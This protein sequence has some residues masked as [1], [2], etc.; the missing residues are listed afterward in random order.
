MTVTR[1]NPEQRWQRHLR[2]AGIRFLVPALATAVQVA[3]FIHF[4][5]YL[6]TGDWPPRPRLLLWCWVVALDIGITFSCFALFSIRS[7]NESILT[8]SLLCLQILSLLILV[9]IG[10]LFY[11]SLHDS[12]SIY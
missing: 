4:V 9:R 3:L 7:W 11:A 2:A 5:I 10:V 6:Q 12:A 8:S 1:E